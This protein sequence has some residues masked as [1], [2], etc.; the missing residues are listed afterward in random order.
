MAPE[1]WLSVRQAIKYHKNRLQQK[2]NRKNVQTTCWV[3]FPMSETISAVHSTRAKTNRFGPKHRGVLSPN[4]RW[5]GSSECFNQFALQDMPPWP[6]R[7]RDAFTGPAIFPPSLQMLKDGKNVTGEQPGV[8]PVLLQNVALE[9]KKSQKF[10]RR[11]MTG[12]TN[13]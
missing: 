6:C 3:L 7:S 5:K 2:N 11:A 12:Q 8:Q 9:H 13:R 4:T 1:R 10:L